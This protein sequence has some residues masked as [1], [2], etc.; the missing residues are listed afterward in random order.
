M[1][2]SCLLFLLPFQLWS[3]TSPKTLIQ[4]VTRRFDQVKS[5]SASL[6]MQFQIPGVQ[7]E[8]IAGKVYYKR[9]SRFRIQAKGILF[10]PKQNPYYALQ[11]LRDTTA[12]TA[13][14]SGEERIGNIPM[15]VIQI[16]P[17][18]SGSDLVLGKF[19]IEETRQLIHKAQLTTQSSGTLT[20]EQTYGKQAGYGLPDG[21]RFLIDVDRFKI[22]KA[23]AMEINAKARRGGAAPQRG[24]GE[25]I[26]S[27]SG[28]RL[29]EL[30][31]DKVFEE[32]AR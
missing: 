25:I 27:F 3:Q 5:Y 28:F 8:P 24:I 7:L 30:L 13:I 29:N 16:I 19:W 10:M 32:E 17:R 6:Q 9:P 2:R 4:G 11:L 26:L 12:Y 20:M 22:P 1:I 31:D 14:F 18:Q 23:V 21:I 15:Q